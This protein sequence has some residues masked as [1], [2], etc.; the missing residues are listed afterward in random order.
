MTAVEALTRFEETPYRPPNVWFEEA[1][2]HGLGVELELLA[3]TR[4]LG[5]VPTP[6]EWGG[7]DAQ[8]RAADRHVRSGSERRSPATPSES[9]SNSPSTRRRRLPEARDDPSI[10]AP[11]RRPAVRGR[12]RRRLLEPHPHPQAR[13]RLHQAGPR[14]DL[15]DRHRPGP[16]CG[17][18]RA[19]RLCGRHGRQIVAEGVEDGAELDTVRDLGVHFAQGYHLGHPAPVGAINTRHAASSKLHAVR[20]S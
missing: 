9:S 5:T 13:S 11:R 14:P 7:P 12:H 18:H 20:G 10:T 4:A 19:R 8:R 1:H 6:A 3:I 17:R 2:S 16:S 15:L